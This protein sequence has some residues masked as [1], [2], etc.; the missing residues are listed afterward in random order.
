MPMNW[1]RIPADG[2]P[3]TTVRRWMRRPCPPWPECPARRLR[4][5]EKQDR[6]SRRHATCVTARI[7]FGE[8]LPIRF[9]SLVRWKASRSM[10]AEWP[11]TNARRAVTLCRPR[12]GRPRWTGTSPWESVYFSGNCTDSRRGSPSYARLPEAHEEATG[13]R[14]ETAADYLRAAGIAVRP[15]GVWGRTAL[16]KPANEVTPDLPPKPAS[17]TDQVTP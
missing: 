4:C 5:L 10:S 9:T 7:W 14:R 8:L 17:A 15:P 12:P 3:G 11:S 1:P 13:V 2:C 16:A 6:A